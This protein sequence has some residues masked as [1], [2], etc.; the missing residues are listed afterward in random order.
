VLRASWP[1]EFVRSVYF[2]GQIAERQ[3]ERDKARAFYGRFVEYWGEGDMDRDRV[4][5]ARKKLKGSW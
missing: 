1:I 3:G 5:D 4:A 2:L